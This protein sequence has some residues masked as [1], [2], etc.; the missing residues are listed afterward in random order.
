L[1]KVNNLWIFA[2]AR[3]T[4]AT[5]T[6]CNF[7]QKTVYFTQDKDLVVHSFS[8]HDVEMNI[9]RAQNIQRAKPTGC[10]SRHRDH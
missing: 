2:R 3:V 5:Y 8:D 6:W 1:G 4:D 9:Q 7:D 10:S